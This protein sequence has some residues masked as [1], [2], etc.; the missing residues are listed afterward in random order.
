MIDIE[1]IEIP[2]LTKCLNELRHQNTWREDTIS[3]L[4]VDNPHLIGSY[5]PSHDGSDNELSPTQNVKFKETCIMYVGRD[6]KVYSLKFVSSDDQVPQEKEKRILKVEGRVTAVKVVEYEDTD[7]QLL[8]VTQDLVTDA[9]GYLY[10]YQLDSEGNFK[11]QL[12]KIK[13]PYMHCDIITIDSIQGLSET[14]YAVLV[15]GNHKLY[16]F[17]TTAGIL[18][19]TFEEISYAC[20]TNLSKLFAVKIQGS[21]LMVIDLETLQLEVQTLDLEVEDIIYMS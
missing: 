5:S 6:A 10:V 15:D 12:F 17:N 7:P 18:I 21:E 9:F 16:V 1:P 13:I 3:L 14:S 4:K 19:H 11:E 20:F 2:A 8:V